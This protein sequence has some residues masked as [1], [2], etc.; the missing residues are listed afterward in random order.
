MD[1][2]ETAETA[3]DMLKRSTR[4]MRQLVTMI[5]DGELEGAEYDRVLRKATVNSKQATALME[6]ISGSS[7]GEAAGDA[8]AAA[9][10]GAA[11]P[12]QP[13]R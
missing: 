13:A 8:A 5:E 7:E 9:A 3:I 10:A 1:N 2:L 6:E 4:K 11:D 12:N